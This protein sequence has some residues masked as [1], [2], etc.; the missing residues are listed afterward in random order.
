[1]SFDPDAYL[2][3]LEQTKPKASPTAFDPDAYL[4]KQGKPSNVEPGSPLEGA[5]AEQKGDIVV[6]DTPT[7]PAKFTRSGERFYDGE[8]AQ[9]MF[10]AGGA[11]LK[12]RALEGGLSFLSGGGPLMDE[13]AGA[14][15]ALKSLGTDEKLGDAYRRGRDQTR[16]DVGSATVNASPEVEIAGTK[17][18]VLPMLG[19]AAPSMLAPIPGGPLARIA[20]A[21]WQGLTSAGANST[22]DLTRGEVGDFAK[23][24]AIG[25]GAGLASGAVAEGIAA[26][27]R[28]LAGRATQKAAEADA[29]ALAAL[30]AARDKALR[31]ATSSM[32]GVAAGGAN[33][34]EKME[35]VLASPHDYSPAVVAEARAMRALP[36]V[37]RAMDRAAMGNLEKLGR[38]IPD[39]E[40]AELARA[41]ALAAARPAVVAAETAKRLEPEA[42]VRDVG[43]KAWK[44]LG[45]RAVLGAAGSALGAGVDAA[46][47]NTEAPGMK[48]G[49]LAG[50]LAGPGAV[51]FMR[52]QANSPVVQS[53]ANRLL[54]A[55]MN[56]SAQGVAKTAPLAVSAASQVPRLSKVYAAMLQKYGVDDGGR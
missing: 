46:L 26:P 14:G 10:D 29:A 52:N 33:S 20:S 45:Q 49:G 31:S 15:A 3:K 55:F 48:Y 11:R 27:F 28:A 2:A 21:G 30:Q 43:S 56:S 36:D 24:T 25:G 34:I 54:A 18:P 13:M 4:A 40:A 8:E 53:G 47:G 16:R 37:Q 32:G 38:F 6:V 9:Q 17:M 22:A 23:D 5:L 51:Q 42:I 44:S 39:Y 12:E 50:L 7:G 19:S 1:M 41:E 35:Q